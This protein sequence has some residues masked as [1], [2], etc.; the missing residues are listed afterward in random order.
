MNP[1]VT[2]NRVQSF[3]VPE[4]FCTHIQN[5]LGLNSQQQDKIKVYQESLTSEYKIHLD[6]EDKR[7]GFY[8]YKWYCM[9]QE[10][11]NKILI[12]AAWDFE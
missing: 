6:E 12:K 2:L 8:M 1:T 3:L 11:S 7:K 9:Q 5:T 4:D 10:K